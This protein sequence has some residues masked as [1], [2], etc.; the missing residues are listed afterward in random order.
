MTPDNTVLNGGNSGQY[1]PAPLNTP[2]QPSGHHNGG[3]VYGNSHHFPGPPID[4]NSIFGNP[5]G[6]PQQPAWNSPPAFPNQNSRGNGHSGLGGGGNG[7]GNG[8]RNG[9]NSMSGL[10]GNSGGH[11][12][13][14]IPQSQPMQPYPY[15]MPPA[16]YNP[17]SQQQPY[18]FGNP[19]PPRNYPT[20]YVTTTKEPSLWNQFLYNKSGGKKPTSSAVGVT[21]LRLSSMLVAALAVAIGG[22]RWLA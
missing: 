17:P 5:I 19:P 12:Y 1:H 9:M 4:Q 2:Q 8:D 16:P 11:I 14:Q 10:G 18:A 22:R 21:S 3:N 20:Y 6:Q 7:G 15:G 13:Q